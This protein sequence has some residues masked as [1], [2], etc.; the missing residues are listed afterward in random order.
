MNRLKGKVAV[1]TGGNSGIGEATAKIF[2]KEGAMVIIVDLKRD[3]FN[4]VADKIKAEGGEAIAIPGDVTSVADSKN[5]FKT[6]VEKYGR[7]DILVNC[8]GISDF[9]MPTSRLSDELWNKLIAV[10]QTG[11]FYYSREALQYMEKAQSGVIVNVAS[12]AGVYGN[13]GVAYS[14]AKHAV[15]GMTKNVAIQY[16]GKGIRCNAVCPGATDTGMLTPEVEKKMDQEMWATVNKH[17]CQDIPLIDPIDQAYAILF[18]ASD[19]SRSV[20]GQVMVVDNGR[21]L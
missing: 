15:V 7:V 5:V 6:V 18:F 21:F 14:A 4:A 20:T 9:T 11:T 8:A 2:G 1:I 3:N 19:E 13:A 12:V 16:A 17:Q 10:D